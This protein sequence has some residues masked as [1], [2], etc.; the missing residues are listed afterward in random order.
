MPITRT[1]T[2]PDRL[3]TL[4]RWVMPRRMRGGGDPTSVAVERAGG[5]VCGGVGFVWVD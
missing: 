3:L 2:C 4:R 1:A 5:V